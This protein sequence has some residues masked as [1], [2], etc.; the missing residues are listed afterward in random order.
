MSEVDTFP[1]EQSVLDDLWDGTFIHLNN[2]GT[3]VWATV[4]DEMVGGAEFR[5]RLLNTVEDHIILDPD[6]DAEGCGESID[7]AAIKRHY[8]DA[9]EPGSY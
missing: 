2:E 1:I 6:P 3:I 4:I 8:A 9:S 7:W 5:R